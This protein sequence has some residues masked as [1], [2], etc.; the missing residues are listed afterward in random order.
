MMEDMKHN[1]FDHGNMMENAKE[2]FGDT[3]NILMWMVPIR[4]GERTTDG[5]NYYFHYYST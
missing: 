4:W 5:H 3:N 2:V 1:I